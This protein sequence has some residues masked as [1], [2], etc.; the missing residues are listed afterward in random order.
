MIDSMD[1]GNV[2]AMDDYLDHPRD[3]DMQSYH[4]EQPCRVLFSSCKG[5]THTPQSGFKQLYRRLRSH[6]KPEKLSSKEE[7][8]TSAVLTGV[9]ILVLGCPTE[10]FSKAECEAIRKFILNGGSLFICMAEKAV[11]TNINYI[12]EEFG[13]VVNSDAVVRTV[14]HRY[15]HPKEVL[16]TDG[17]LNREIHEAIFRSSQPVTFSPDAFA[18]GGGTL[19]RN[20]EE[21]FKKLEIVY[22]HGATLSIQKP[23]VA[24]LSS[25]KIA[26]RK[27]VV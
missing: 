20:F 24:L 26:D 18:Y 13:I 14:H 25:G 7:S 4:M 5:E 10:K 22:P 1:R 3:V 21:N 12:L 6:Y 8:I 23:A 17:V 11:K 16:I 2:A 19:E 9:S 15:M 27:S